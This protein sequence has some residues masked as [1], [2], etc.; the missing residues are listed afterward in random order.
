MKVF[1]SWSGSISREVA[2]ALRDWLPFVIQV[3]EPYVSSEDIDPGARWSED[4]AVQLDDTDFGILCVTR[5]NVSTPWLNF[6][7]G[8]LSKSVERS[9]VVPFLIGL[10]PSD[11]PRGPL[12]QF[13]AVEPTQA[14]VLRLVRGMNELCSALP[15]ERLE[16][17]VNVWWPHLEE[18]LR[19]LQESDQLA[20]PSAPQRSTHDML[21]ELLE[22]TR[23]LQ[24][25]LQAP[26]DVNFIPSA[27][28]S[29]R[30]P[31]QEIV[32]RF[33]RLAHIL[34]FKVTDLGPVHGPADLKLERGGHTLYVEVYSGKNLRARASQVVNRI[35]HKGISDPLI[36]ILLSSFNSTILAEVQA[37]LGSDVHIVQWYDVHD[38]S[39]LK[40]LLEQLTQA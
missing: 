15:T 1:I 9:R 39:K 7:A 11:I 10:G 14:G 32:E 21:S 38:D 35:R 30:Y 19:T 5:D 6:E 12:V 31:E 33:G 29:Y 13:Q 22:L 17:V 27:P 25:E 28:S 18:R 26:K 16:E 40:A 8:A 2:T 24:R 34:D 37:Q 23:G 3:V 20:G 4:I 36:L